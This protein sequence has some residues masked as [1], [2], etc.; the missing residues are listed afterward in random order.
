MAKFS[1]NFKKNAHNDKLPESVLKEINK[2]F[3]NFEYEE[4]KGAY[5]L[6]PKNKGTLSFVNFEI[7]NKK[8]YQD[9]LK[10]E[11]PS[12]DEIYSY[13]YNSQKSLDLKEKENS[14][15]VVDG[16]KKSYPI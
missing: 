9:K 4:N 11:N 15:M 10:K 1:K 7:I 8:F 16:Q 13:S 2:Q 6:V 12:F 5:I 14:Y 3:K